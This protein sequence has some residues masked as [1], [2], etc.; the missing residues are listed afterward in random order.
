VLFFANPCG[1]AVADAMQDKRLGFIDTPAQGNKRP[2]GVVWCADNGCFGKGYPGDEK[3]LAWLAKN[4][5]ASADCLFATAPDIVGDAAGTLERSAPFLPMIRAL[6]YPAALVAQ[7]GLEDLEVPWG[8]FDVLFIGGSTDWKL[9]A[10]ARDLIAQAKARG[11]GVHMGRVNS[12]RRYRYAHELGVD[13]VDGTYLTFGPDINLPKLLAWS[14]VEN[15]LSL[16][17]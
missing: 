7:D 13:S 2:G 17:T 5:N 6:G 1:P 8:E 10:A 3:W 14:R 9:G 12:E 16:F 4:A 11:K 15:Q